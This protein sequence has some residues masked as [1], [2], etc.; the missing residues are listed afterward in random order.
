MTY[1]YDKRE[2]EIQNRAAL[3]NIT[4]TT[5]ITSLK[6]PFLVR[7]PDLAASEPA[8]KRFPPSTLGEHLG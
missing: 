7:S 8:P 6:H 2:S 3:A 1:S 5:G 4:G